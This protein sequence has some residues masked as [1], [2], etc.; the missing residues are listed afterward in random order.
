MGSIRSRMSELSNDT[1]AYQAIQRTLRNCLVGF[2]RDRLSHQIENP[3][4]DIEALFKA[5]QWDAARASA[6]ASRAA[7]RVNRAPRDIFDE[8]DVPHLQNVFERYYSMLFPETSGMPEAEKKQRQAILGW[9]RDAVEVRNP[10]AHPPEVDMPIEDLL[11][12]LDSCIRLARV[13]RRD[14]A[15][16]ELEALFGQAIARAVPHS[17]TTSA[18]IQVLLPPR[19]SVVVDFI[20]RIRYLED[21]WAWIIDDLSPRRLL[22]GDGGKG[23]SSIAYQFA[24]S[25]AAKPPR[26]VEGILWLGAKARRF[27]AGSIVEI[28][29]PDFH[30]LDSALDR[31]L[32]FYGEG[33]RIGLSAELKFHRVLELLA[34][35]PILL[36][37]DDL[38]TI[39]SEDDD[40][41]DFLAADVSRTGSKTLIT[42]RR[43]FPG[44]GRA[45]TKVESFSLDET[46][47]FVRSRSD[48]LQLPAHTWSDRRISEIHRI[49]EGSPL[50]I[51]DL[52]RLA[53]NDSIRRA[54]EL[55]S[56]H[57]GDEARRYALKRELEMLTAV[58]QDVLRTLA[59]SPA[60]LSCLEIGHILNWTEDRAKNGLRELEELYLVPTAELV[61]GVP[62]FELHRNLSVL[63]NREMNDPDTTLYD[64]ASSRRMKT[65]IT[66]VLG[67]DP[68]LGVRSEVYSYLSQA[69]A[70]FKRGDQELA[71]RT[72]DEALEAHPNQPTLYEKRAWIAKVGIPRRAVDARRFWKRAYQLG[73]RERAMYREWIH[74]EIQEHA[75]ARAAEVAEM[76]LNRID[77]NDVVALQIGGYARSRLGQELMQTGQ[78]D[79]ARREYRQADGMLLRAIRM[80]GSRAADLD[81]S[82][83]YRAWVLNG[84]ALSALEPIKVS[85]E[86]RS[87]EWSKQMPN[88]PN[89]QHSLELLGIAQQ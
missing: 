41:I 27:E 30:D 66:G 63:V 58:G 25:L 70:A 74:M 12:V 83:A 23:K 64:P 24:T 89:A 87:R 82:R 62:R 84:Q 60:P 5:E 22:S 78:T 59:L 14:K 57:Q 54:I 81:R 79:A 13:C 73:A 71:E 65:A 21:L 53:K 44:F 47:D 42:S 11:R 7:G 88:D 48:L 4:R 36:I 86:E 15:V 69:H 10:I 77:S 17:T 56:D 9:L 51:E 43:P 45:R 32:L 50:Y 68:L 34:D 39:A 55:W 67:E 31:L 18:S 76:W 80:E 85:I 28:A 19:E 40:V 29:N 35:F 38:D 1:I 33:D 8:L 52:L 61:E 37:I 49:C 46:A 26:N 2:V 16:G 72:L 6:A 75:W 3:V 20:G